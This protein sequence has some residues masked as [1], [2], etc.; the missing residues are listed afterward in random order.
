MLGT[1]ELEELG[2]KIAGG[3]WQFECIARRLRHSVP[4]ADANR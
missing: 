4:P 1:N 2:K 3:Q